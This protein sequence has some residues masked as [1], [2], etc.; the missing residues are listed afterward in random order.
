LKDKNQE[1]Q[2]KK[3]GG[4]LSKILL[5]LN[6]RNQSKKLEWTNLYI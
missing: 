6:D 4:D 2:F 5:K 1:E 3:S